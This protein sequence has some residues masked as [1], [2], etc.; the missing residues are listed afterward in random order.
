MTASM[1]S[2]AAIRLTEAMA[3]A[4]SRVAPS[5]EEPGAP[6]RQTLLATQLRQLEEALD[7]L[8]DDQLAG[9]LGQFLEGIARSGD[10]NDP[11]NPDVPQ[12]PDTI[13]PP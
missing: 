5:I 11:E 4:R 8:T 9:H 6:G 7:G 10:G 1:D 13:P 2:I 3:A 12:V